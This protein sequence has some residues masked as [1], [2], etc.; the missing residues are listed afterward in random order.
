MDGHEARCGATSAARPS[1]PPPAEVKTEEEEAA[2]TLD[3]PN[4]DPEDLAVEQDEAPDINNL[5]RNTAIAQQ[6]ATISLVAAQRVI[7]EHQAQLAPRLERQDEDHEQLGRM[8]Q[9]VRQVTAEQRRV[10]NQLNAQ[11]RDWLDARLR[12]SRIQRQPFRATPLRR[13]PNLD[14]AGA[15]VWRGGVLSRIWRDRILGAAA[16]AVITAAG[17]WVAAV[18]VATICWIFR[19]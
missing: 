12:A 3:E 4:G 5:I 16:G 17:L 18:S 19:R 1:Q 9:E 14:L 7:T 13:T 6:L 15:S 10:T 8:L 2:Q 11:R